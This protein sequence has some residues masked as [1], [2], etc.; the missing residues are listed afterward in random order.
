MNLFRRDAVSRARL[1]LK[2]ARM[3]TVEQRDE[4]EAFLESSIVFGRAA[5][6]RL[7]STFGKH[8]N[9]PEWWDSLRGNESVEFFREERD[10]L[11]KEGPTKVGQVIRIGVRTERAEEHYY[12]ESADVPATTTVENHLNQIEHLVLEAEE[13]FTGKRE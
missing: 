9:W 3:C 12:F 11:L 6:H 1:F 8:P 7:K 10:Y 2:M 4:Y 5:L 13:R